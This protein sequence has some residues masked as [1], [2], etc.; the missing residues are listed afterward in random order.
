MT[1]YEIASEFQ[2]FL[3]VEE[4]SLETEAKLDQLAI[5]LDVKVD[6]ICRV[7]AELEGEVDAL[8]KECNRLGWQFE[9]REGR[10][11]RL[12]RYMKESLEKIGQLKVKT[13]LFSVSVQKNSQP[14][15]EVPEDR[16]EDLP[17]EFKRTKVE[18]ERLKI[19]AAWREKRELPD[20]V[21][22]IQGTHIRVR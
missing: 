16:I 8:R 15:V 13:P 10:I 9:Q 7:I 21:K 2:Q 17:D 1:L 3:D 12:K 14:S 18:A 19:A 20:F 22:V 11:A 6:G 4:L 5:A